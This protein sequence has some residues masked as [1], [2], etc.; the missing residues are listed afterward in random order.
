MPRPI[1]VLAP[2]INQEGMI[3]EFLE[4]LRCGVMGWFRVG[5]AYE[6]TAHRPDT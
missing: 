6:A 1:P 3:F 4:W 5:G 2:V